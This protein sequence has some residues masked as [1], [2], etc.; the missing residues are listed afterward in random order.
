[1]GQLV[2]TSTYPEKRLWTEAGSTPLFTDASR[3]PA[4]SC[5]FGFTKAP[6]LLPLLARHVK[7]HKNE[8]LLLD[9]Q[10]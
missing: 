3:D 5:S 6:S 7:A 9:L 4:V 8:L 10:R 1:M 2:S